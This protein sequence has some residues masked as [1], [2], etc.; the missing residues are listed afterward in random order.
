MLIIKYWVS[1][2]L[3]G[4]ILGSRGRWIKLQQLF[5]PFTNPILVMILM[6][7]TTRES[8]VKGLEYALTCEGNY[9]RWVVSYNLCS[10]VCCILFFSCIAIAFPLKEGFLRS[11]LDLQSFPQ[12]EAQIRKAT[13]HGLWC[14]VRLR[15]PVGLW[16]IMKMQ[17][18]FLG[19]ESRVVEGD[20]KTLDNCCFPANHS[21]NHLHPDAV[22]YHHI[23]WDL[24]FSET[25]EW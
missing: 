6:I 7:I 22:H 15:A 2:V 11:K 24:G 23:L 9:I 13:E 3:L 1:K 16:T 20:W 18:V 17:H 19:R 21:Q 8:V 4:I 12:L 14:I 10:F 5:I 25:W